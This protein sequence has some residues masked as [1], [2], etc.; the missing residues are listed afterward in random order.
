MVATSVLITGFEPF[1]GHKVNPSQLVAESFEG[2]LIAGRPLRACVLPVV[3]D[4]VAAEL[5]AAL[6]RGQPDIVICMGQAG[7]TTGIAVER[8]A[9]NVLELKEPDNAGVLRSAAAIVTGGPD[10][11]LSTLPFKDIVAAWAE[12]GIPGFLSNSAG[13]FVCNQ[14][15]YH[16]L[17]FAEQCSPPFVAGFVHVPYLPE[18][19]ALEGAERTPSMSL[20]VM[21]AAVEILI[22]T[23]VAWLEQRALDST[24]SVT[25][26]GFAQTSGHTVKEVER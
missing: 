7:G 14:V 19:A 26:P 21:K 22:T 24:T 15:L 18:Q 16:A 17:G 1:G 12:N 23:V 11:R 13:T 10:A 8:V 9:V 5:K 2:R 4:K 25:V 6:E 20:D 3:T